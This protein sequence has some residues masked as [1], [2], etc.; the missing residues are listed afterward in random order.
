MVTEYVRYCDSLLAL[1]KSGD[2]KSWH[3]SWEEY[4]SSRW[5]LSKTRAKLLCNFAKFRQLLEAELFGTLP[6][7]PEQVKAV[8]ALP[9]KQ[10]VETWE[11]VLAFCSLPIR[12]SNVEAALQHFHIYANKRVPPD[13]LK[14]Q[15]VRRA[16]KTL[17][18][19]ENGEQLVAEIGG[20]G[21][22]KNWEKAVEVVI[23]AHQA[24]LNERKSV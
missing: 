19:M 4:V 8:L 6:E 20:N 23:D 14:A 5:G 12:P 18:G 9:Q 1:R 7:T 16:A 21:L 24:K 15:R 17:A 3:D 22:G 2:W 10:W 11:L 13:V